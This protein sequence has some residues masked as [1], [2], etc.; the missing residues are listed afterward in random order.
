MEY[1]K[2][3][4]IQNFQFWSGAYDR[5]KDLTSDKKGQLQ[6]YIEECFC[7]KTPTETEINDFVW[8]SC[9]DFLKEITTDWKEKTCKMLDET[10]PN[11]KQE[12]KDEYLVNNDCDTEEAYEQA[13][14]DF[15]ETYWANHAEDVIKEAGYELDDEI[16]DFIGYYWSNGRTDEENLKELYNY[17]NNK[18]NDNRTNN[19]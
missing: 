13:E 12:Y 2:D 4:D 9:D 8:F 16:Q 6:Q 15:R 11:Y 17:L 19:N 3:F 5:V 10:F 7:N 14:D 1:T 18:E